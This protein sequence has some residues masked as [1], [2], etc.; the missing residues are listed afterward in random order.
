MTDDSNGLSF[1]TTGTGAANS[2]VTF[3]SAMS[4]TNGANV[5]IG[6]TSQLQSNERL[7]ITTSTNT[8]ILAKFTGGSTTGWAAKFWN[9]GTSGDNLIIEFLTE[10]SITARG[11]VTY[12]RGSGVTAF[13]TTS[14]YRIKSEISDFNSLNI[15]SNLKPKEFKIGNAPRKTI[16]FIAH[17]LQEFFPQAVTGIKDQID[18]FGNPIYQSV[19]YSQLTG[20]LVKAI[21]ELKQEIDTLKNN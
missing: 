14:D 13:N 15:I 10:T 1:L 18:N 21:Q 3:T 8:A 4:I 2:A 7:A 19:D 17:E 6:T 20:L 5:L 12:N 11:S 16:G 9:N